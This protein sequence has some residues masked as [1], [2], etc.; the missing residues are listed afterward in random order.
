MLFR[1]LKPNKFYN[2]ASKIITEDEATDRKEVYWKNAR[3]DS[4]NKNEKGIYAMV[5]SVQ[6]VPAY[7]TYVDIMRIIFTGY[8]RIGNIE[9]GSYLTLYSH[10]SNEGGRCKLDARTSNVFSKKMQ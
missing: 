3:H 10:N 6:S 7:K 4:L 5:D 8:K 1:S 2:V 9:L